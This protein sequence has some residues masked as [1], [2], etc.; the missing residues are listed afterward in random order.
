MT[1]IDAIVEGIGATRNLLL[2]E[3]ENDIKL[4]N[5]R[6]TNN[7]MNIERKLYEDLN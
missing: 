3:D 1:G 2:L 6:G 7:E 4:F 5:L